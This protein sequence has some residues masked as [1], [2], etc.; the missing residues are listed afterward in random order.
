MSAPDGEEAGE[1]FLEKNKTAEG[2]ITLNSGL[3]YKVLRAGDGD[4]H[5]TV[6]S[7]CE[8]HYEG[9]TA[10]N[11]PSGTK[12][13]SSYDRGSPA[14]FAPNQVIKGWT[15]AMQLMVEGDKWEMFIPSD[16]AY[17]DNGRPPGDVGCWPLSEMSAGF[18]ASSSSPRDGLKLSAASSA[19]ICR[20]PPPVRSGDA[21]ELGPALLLLLLLPPADL[22]VL[23]ES[24]RS[25]E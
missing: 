8:C 17:G 5:P 11:Y 21:G 22:L 1:A 13:D 4:S 3:Q 10:Q 12:F 9:R 16:L 19:G 2:V 20:P 15:E 18:D 25:L 14:T 7:P 23:P 6:S 24:S